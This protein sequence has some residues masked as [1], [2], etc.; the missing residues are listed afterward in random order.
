MSLPP[1]ADGPSPPSLR[2]LV[3]DDEP[4]IGSMIARMLGAS[5]DVTCVLSGQAGLDA[6]AH[7]GAFDLV[8]CD[9]MMPGLTGMDVHRRLQA[10]GSRHAQSLI[11]LTGGAFVGHA[12]SFLAQNHNP[13]LEK[14]FMAAELREIV[15]DA[16]SSHDLRT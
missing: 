1:P 10:Q 8:L 3:I 15:R 14:P 9:L 5:F 13:C 12:G 11:F 7:D 4:L 2:V 6:L 16:V